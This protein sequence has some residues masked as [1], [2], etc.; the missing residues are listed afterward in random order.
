MSYFP[1]SLEEP[2]EVVK[3]A[4]RSLSCAIAK[5]YPC[6]AT[7]HHRICPEKRKKEAAFNLVYR[8]VPSIYTDI[9]LISDQVFID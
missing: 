6:M 2:S 1:K 4:M 7:I 8:V 3:P 5:Q 9:D